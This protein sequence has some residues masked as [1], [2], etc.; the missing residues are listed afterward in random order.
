MTIKLQEKEVELKMSFR[1][2][3]LY[4]NITGKSFEPTTMTDII[5]FFYCVIITS[6]KDYDYKYNDFL[7]ALDEDANLM[8]QFSEWLTNEYTKNGMLS[9]SEDET[10]KKVMKKKEK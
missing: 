10:K 6:S 2:Y 4:E 3:M 7:D 9:P 1:A 5:N 8:I